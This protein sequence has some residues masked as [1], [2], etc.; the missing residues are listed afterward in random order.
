MESK[1]TV[2]FDFDGTLANSVELLFNLFNEHAEEFGYDKATWDEI[3]ALRRMSYKNAMKHK[4]VKV[5]HLPRM[6]ITIGREM[7]QRMDEVSPYDG[8]VEVLENLQKDGYSIG[9]LTSNQ[10]ALVKDFFDA[11]NFPSFNFIVSEKTLFGK[12]K[13]IKRV[14]KRYELDQ[15]EVVYVGD[16]PRDVAASHKAG[17]R[18][19]GVTWGVGGPE[20]FEK[21]PPDVQVSKTSKL[22]KAIKDLLAD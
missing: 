20:G 10:A 21:Q 2:I 16:E 18:I 7:R 19:V 3:S 9:V 13:A 1:K 6:I 4:G 17:I 14:L 12:D 22:E 8:I 15:S 11:H 5:R